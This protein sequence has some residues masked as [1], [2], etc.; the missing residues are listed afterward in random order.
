MRRQRPAPHSLLLPR[1]PA[2]PARL[3]SS[4]FPRFLCNSPQQ[5]DVMESVNDFKKI[6]QG[7]HYGGAGAL[8]GA[9]CRAARS[10]AV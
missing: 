5:I 4:P 8:L 10:A 2:H 7:L 3:P 6:T 9:A 1:L